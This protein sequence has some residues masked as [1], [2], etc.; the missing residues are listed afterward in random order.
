MGDCNFTYKANRQKVLRKSAA[1]RAGGSAA[2]TDN[3]PNGRRISAD[4]LSE[5]MSEIENNKLESALEKLGQYKDQFKIEKANFTK[6]GNSISSQSAFLEAGNNSVEIRFV[7]GYEPTQVTNPKQNIKSG[8]YTVTRR[9]GNV[10]AYRTLTETKTKSIKNAKKNY[11]NVIDK[12]KR[13]TG[14]D[15]IQF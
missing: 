12:W 2:N 8:I 14:Q 15:R 13:V 4:R 10:K 6:N 5:M 3:E 11:D 1:A 7:S 9:G